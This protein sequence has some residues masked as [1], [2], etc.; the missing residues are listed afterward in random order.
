MRTRPLRL[1]AGFLREFV[2]T[3]AAGGVLASESG[4]DVAQFAADLLESAL[5]GLQRSEAS[6]LEERFM[7]AVEGGS[8]APGSTPAKT[9][10]K[11]PHKPGQR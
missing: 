1:S 9:A 7:K 10:K 4:R 11:K 2:E 3:I 6:D 8:R 5:P